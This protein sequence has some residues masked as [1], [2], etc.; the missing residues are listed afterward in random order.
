MATITPVRI[1]L[2]DHG[3]RMTLEEF[4]DAEEQEGYR[5]ELAR[6][7][8]EV[9]HVPGERHGLI[10]GYFYDAI[11]R[12][13]QGKT[14]RILRYGG[15]SELRLWLPT[16]VSGRNPDVAVVLRNTPRDVHDHLPPALAIEVVSE[17]SEAHERD[18]ATRREEYLAYGLREYWIVDPFLHRVTVLIRN[19]DA[20]V[21]RVFVDGQTAEGLVLPGFAIPVNDIWAAA[22]QADEPSAEA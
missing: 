22:A 6:A 1:G 9:T 14:D 4:F 16:P 17:G 20:W 12:Y 18:Y 5:Y 8:L 13:R 11:S 19:G 15:A 2:G 3:R 7:I 21:E 10:V